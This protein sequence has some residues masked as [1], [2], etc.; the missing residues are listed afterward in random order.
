MSLHRSK[1]NKPKRKLTNGACGTRRK[2]KKTLSNWPATHSH[3]T[4]KSAKLC[5]LDET[6]LD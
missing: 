6:K 2:E 5:F 1:L 4:D 3:A